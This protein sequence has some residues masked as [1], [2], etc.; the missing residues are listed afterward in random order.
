MIKN[1]INYIGLLWVQTFN[2]YRNKLLIET[3]ILYIYIYIY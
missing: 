3:K 1:N 2:P